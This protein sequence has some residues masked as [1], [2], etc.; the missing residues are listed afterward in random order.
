MELKRL[1]VT[2]GTDNPSPIIH[3]QEQ[4]SVSSSMRHYAKKFNEDLGENLTVSM[5]S[6]SEIQQSG[7]GTSPP[8]E[9]KCDHEPFPFP[10]SQLENS[11]KDFSISA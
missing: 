5:D 11:G 6:G 1:Q 8:Q 7:N 10:F 9:L 2:E 3:G 4:N